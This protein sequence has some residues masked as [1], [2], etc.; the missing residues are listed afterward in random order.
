MIPA[1]PD[2]RAAFMAA[3]ART[4]FT[5]CCMLL[6]LGLLLLSGCPKGVKPPVHKTS[7]P[8]PVWN[9]FIE[10]SRAQAKADQT[11]AFSLTA[12]LHYA[13]PKNS[14]RVNIRFWGDLDGA[15]RIDLQTGMGQTLGF[16]HEDERGF[17]AFIPD[18]NTAYLHSDARRGIA[19]FGVALPFTLREL[20]LLLNGRWSGLFP[21]TYVAARAVPGKGFSF[22]VRQGDQDFTL[23]LDA[24]GLPM[25][26][27]TAG[28]ESW[29]LEFSDYDPAAPRLPKK[30]VMTREPGEK[31]VLVIKKLEQLSTSW[32]EQKL[33]LD[34]PPDARIEDLGLNGA[35]RPR[36]RSHG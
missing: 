22:A 8:A 13:G 33:K 14:S 26:M 30:I 6:A 3:P 11:K 12:G 16:W 20:G 31:A 2:T 7:D 1:P 34:L 25:G 5:A 19:A 29:K 17:T 21:E 10:E 4:P 18:K 28:A 9:R 27:T 24:E 36:G 32:P 35:I 23:L 15:S